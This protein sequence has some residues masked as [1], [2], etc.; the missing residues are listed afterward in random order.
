MAS[1]LFGGRLTGRNLVRLVYI[2]EAGLSKSSQ[3]PFL[4][5]AGV[6]V[7][8]DNKLNL[9][10]QHLRKL[11]KKHIPEHQRD[12]FI[13][14]AKEL[15]HG[16][17]PGKAF[18]RQDP[19]WID[20]RRFAVADD[21]ASIPKKFQ[22][23]LAFGWVDRRKFPT[24]FNF[25]PDTAE[26]EKVI[27]AHMVAYMSC[28]MQVEQW[29]RKNTQNEVCMMIAEDNADSRRFIRETQQY[30]QRS[31][32]SSELDAE[33]RKH[34]P[35]RKIKEDPA[36]QQ[37]R[38]GHPLEIADFCAYVFKRF[39]INN[40]DAKFSRF[41]DPVVEQGQLSMKKLARLT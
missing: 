7:H 12:G 40:S 33:S 18:D 30:H 15:F 20:E 19:Y 32:I 26:K 2:D 8:S 13:F 31:D 4:V 14:H 25:E 36:F 27:G 29:M 9:V 35:F 16:G 41:F 17:K 11:V 28:A 3:E 24:T 5:V 38:P 6:V 1:A 23:P 10:E 21:L 34:F 37:K 39:L 22:L